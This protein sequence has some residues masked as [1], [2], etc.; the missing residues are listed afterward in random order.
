MCFIV[1]RSFRRSARGVLFLFLLML[2][3]AGNLVA[4]WTAL[5][6]EGGDVRSLA[7][8][9][10]HPERIFLGTSAGQMF[11]SSDNGMSW[12]RFAHLGEGDDYVLDNIEVD[13]ES[14]AIYAGAWTP[15]K[16]G[17]DLF[18][19]RDGGL[20]WSV[21]S[22]MRGKS[23]RALAMAP[24][25]PKI[26]VVG[27]L[28][29]V[30]RSRDG[31]EIWERIS[32]SDDRRFRNVESVAIDP[33]NPHMIYVGTWHLGWKTAD[34][35]ET[36]RPIKNG[37][38]DDSDVFSITIDY[39]DSRNI[40]LSTC[41]GIYKSEYSAEFFHRLNGI[42]YSARRSRVLKQDPVNPL[43]FYAGTTDG[44]WRSDDAGNSWR[45]LLAGVTVNDV[46]LDAR[47]PSR[48]LLATDRGGV[49]LSTDGG[50]TFAPS[51]RG[52][53]HRSVA[54][55]LVDAED[56]Q[57]I[58]AGV[59]N[60]KE[61]GGVLVSRDRGKNWRQLST[62]MENL[63]IFSLAQAEDGDLLAGTSNGIYRLVRGSSVWQAAGT[64]FLQSTAPVQSSPSAI[65]T[66]LPLWTKITLQTR[67]A[68]LE[69]TPRKWFAATAMGLYESRDQ[70]RSWQGGPLIGHKDFRTVHASNSI[71]LATTSRAALLSSDGGWS[72]TELQLPA[73]VTTVYGAT[74]EAGNILWLATHQGALRSSDAGAT[75]ELVAPHLLYHVTAIVYAEA[76]H[77]LLA[78]A[79]AGRLFTS[80]DGGRSWRIEHTGF[81]LRSIAA[82]HGRLFAA[83]SFNG[84]IA[85]G[86]SADAPVSATGK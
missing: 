35:G 26:L 33:Q 24:S 15:E 22:G 70:G 68:Q 51:N 42:P 18:R 1:P 44:L 48:V 40:Y 9:P 7:E 54:S 34:G 79:R 38:V 41:S 27:A 55:V 28:D 69:I 72:W 58:Y 49:L 64:V 13:A 11:L 17:G 84:V 20:T 45:A 16:A 57:T 61:F 65:P 6:P 76:D 31:G 4:Q 52:F 10:R 12:S 43:V 37:V 63:D 73:F 29:G 77:R 56:S 75:W 47:D 39:S 85:Q 82:V 78:I 5:G 25:D 60:D 30:Y 59:L 2:P 3:G 74:V 23:I 14:G 86:A 66:R 53:S 50:V 83:T 8:D 80:T 67:V 81:A 19:S 46:Q 21:L 32:P 36:W 71:V 62:G